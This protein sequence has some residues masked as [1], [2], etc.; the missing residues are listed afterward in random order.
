MLLS[1]LD[2]LEQN[3]KSLSEKGLEQI[4]RMIDLIT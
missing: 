1:N 3:F 2:N 4:A